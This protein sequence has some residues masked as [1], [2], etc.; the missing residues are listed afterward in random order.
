MTQE[1]RDGRQMRRCPFFQR[2]EYECNEKLRCAAIRICHHKGGRVG[3]RSRP[4]HNLDRCAVPVH[5]QIGAHS[6]RGF[7]SSGGPVFV[8]GRSGGKLDRFGLVQLAYSILLVMA[9]IAPP[10]QRSMRIIGARY[11]RIDELG[12]LVLANVHAVHNP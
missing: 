6:T 7:R 10:S 5:E 12:Q 3:N 9:A 1:P 11:T 4:L 2:Y 8:L